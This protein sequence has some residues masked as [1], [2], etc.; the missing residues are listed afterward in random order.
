MGGD[1]NERFQRNVFGVAQ[2]VAEYSA[3][4]ETT[5][6]DS[7]KVQ[8]PVKPNTRTYRIWMAGKKSGANGAQ[9]VGVRIGATDVITIAADGNDAA[10]WVAEFVIIITGGSTQ[11]CA[12]H[13]IVESADPN[14]DYAAGTVDLSQGPT[15]VPFIVSAHGSDTVYCE[16]CTVEM[17]IT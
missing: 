14:V 16:M 2:S 5:T 7:A 6:I 1:L 15:M 10:D 11:K 9:S 17:G 3:T 4:N 12:G 8:I 13:F